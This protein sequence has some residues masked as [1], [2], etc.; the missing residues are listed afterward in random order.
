MKPR[1]LLL[2]FSFLFTMSCSNID[3]TFKEDDSL[4]LILMETMDEPYSN[5]NKEYVFKLMAQSSSGLKQVVISNLTHELDSAAELPNVVLAEDI[6]VDEN[7]YFSRP[8]KTAIIEYPILVPELPGETIGL[9]FTVTAVNGMKQTIHSSMLI[10]NYQ[11]QKQL[12]F[13]NTYKSKNYAFYSTANQV[14]YGLSSNLGTY[15]KKHIQDIDFYS[16]SDGASEYFIFSPDEE[17]IVSYIENHGD[18]N[19]VPSEMRKTLLVKLDNVDF[20]S[21]KDKEILAIDFTNTVG[22]IQVKKGDNIG[23]LLADGRKGIMNIIGASGRY[24]DFKCKVQTI[25][26]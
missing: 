13:A 24:L 8:V 14:M 9:D 22:K 15:Y 10:A 7:G 1:Y 21:V 26:Q 23:F 4:R 3:E 5:P 25:A 19:Y 16:I 18:M 6:T 2:I 20:K 17:E 11:E 12:F